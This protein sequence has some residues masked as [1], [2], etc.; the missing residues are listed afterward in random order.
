[1]RE[2][3][4]LCFNEWELKKWLWETGRQKQM[5][6]NIKE[7]IAELRQQ[8]LFLRELEGKGWQDMPKGSGGGDG[9]GM[10]IVRISE[11]EEMIVK[12]LLP[13]LKKLLQRQ[14]Q[15]KKMLFGSPLKAEEC[16]MI[17]MRYLQGKNWNA[18]SRELYKSKS[19]CY[20][21]HHVAIKK[22]LHYI[23]KNNGMEKESG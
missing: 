13:K 10:K 6:E 19:S 22:L 11:I 4:N 21:C 12:E 14:R 8:Q 1:M 18:I 20:R 9:I 7:E 23:Q 16:T 2:L 15:L 17:C 3:K 5:I